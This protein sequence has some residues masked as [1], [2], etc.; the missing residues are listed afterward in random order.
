[1]L[2]TL[3][4]ADVPAA[5]AQ[6]VTDW[7]HAGATWDAAGLGAV[8]TED[9]M[10][11][12][13]RSGHSVGRGEIQAYFASYQ[14]VILGGSMELYDTELRTLTGDCVLAQ[15][16]LNFAFHLASGQHT[17]STL[18]A[19][20]VLRQDADRWRILDHHFSAVPTEPPLGNH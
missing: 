3:P 16:M 10:L 2:D 17:R 18:R 19:T 8:Y 12:G 13:G 11:F 4:N 20:L 15:G 14:G 6:V 1:M 7:N 5:L 9:A